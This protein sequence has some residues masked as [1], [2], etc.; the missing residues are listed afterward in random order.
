MNVYLVQVVDAYGPNKF[1]PLAIGYQWCYADTTGYTLKDVLIEKIPPKQYVKTMEN[2][3]LV[4]MS[5]YIWNWEYNKEL[6]KEIKRRFRNCV[7]I[8]GGPQVSKHDPN[9][10]DKAPMFDAFIHGE[11]EEAFKQILLAGL[12]CA[13]WKHIPN[14]QTLYNMP[15]PAQRRKD[16]SKIPSPILEGFYEPI[17]AKYPKDIMWQVTWES[18]RGC[19]YHCAFCDIGDDYWNK[20]TLFD[21]DRV[22]A[23]IDWMGRNQIEYVS[24][25]DS[26]WGLLERDKEI[27]Q[28]VIDTK[29]KYGYPRWWDATWAKNNVDRNFDIAMMNKAGGVNI[30]KGVTFAMQSF[31]DNTLKASERFNINEQQVTEYLDKYKAEGIPTYSELIWPM[32]EETYDSLKAGVQKLIDLGQDSFLMIHP[33]VI[34]DNATMGNPQYQKKYGIETKKVPLDTYY[35]SADD[36]ENYIVEYTD[37]VYSTKTASWN[38]VLR[39]HMFS[40]ISILMYYYGWGHYLAKY[41]RKQGVLEKDFFE[42]LLNWIATNPDTMLYKEYTETLVHIHDTFH[43]KRFWGRKVRGDTDIYWEYKGASS[44][45][46]HDNHELFINEMIQF[47]TV[48]YPKIDAYHAVMMNMLACRVKDKVYPHTVKVNK[49]ICKDM[50]DLDTD[51]IVIDHS[52]KSKPDPYLWYNKAYHWDRKS[53][54]WACTISDANPPVDKDHK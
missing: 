52:D 26:N 21:M 9:L 35:L 6:A 41:M 46:I 44:I 47:M 36:L 23:E 19:P 40:W 7:I 12:D 10:F 1:L 48:T 37:A 5:S 25:C 34:T 22:K 14:V 16:L 50:F 27:T 45:V 13:N 11:G 32:P 3:V 49:Q 4:A 39:G 38:S 24:V 54:Y 30:F 51:T 18:L 29:K 15:K 31:N 42:S 33:L 8:T 20:L 43:E 53:K 17:M 2:P 28:Y